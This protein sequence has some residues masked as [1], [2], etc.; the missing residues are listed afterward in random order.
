M[1]DVVAIE[2]RLA[3]GGSRYFLTWGR[4]QHPVDPS[5]VCNL[6]LQASSMFALGSDPVSAQLCANLREAAESPDAP[7]FYECFLSFCHKPVPRGD[8][9]ET[10]RISMDLAMRAG[11]EIAYCGRRTESRG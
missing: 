9:Y 1:D 8:G 11:E 4:I 3:D 7:S 2:V 6:V 10:W 5:P